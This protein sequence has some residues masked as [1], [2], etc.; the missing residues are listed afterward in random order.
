M[1]LDGVLL[2]VRDLQRSIDFYKAILRI[3]EIDRPS[4]EFAIVRTTG[5]VIYL[6]KDSA[7]VSVRLEEMN[8]RPRRGIGTILHF[9][10]ENVDEWAAHCK[11]SGY[12]IDLEPTSQPFG[13]RQCYIYDPD[14]YN[15]VIEH[16]L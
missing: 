11:A 1:R 13:R 3:N 10:V 4:D 12:P 9:A 2:Y 6:H 16:T 7:P 14:G 5:A 15:I 8:S